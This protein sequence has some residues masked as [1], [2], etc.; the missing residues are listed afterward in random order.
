MCGRY[1]LTVSKK[2]LAEA[3]DLHEVQLRELPP[4]YNI[5]PLQSVPVLLEAPEPRVELFRWGLIPSWAKDPAIGDRMIPPPAF[6][7]KA[8][9]FHSESRITGP[10]G[11]RQVVGMINAR[12]ETLTEKPSFRDP[13]RNQRCLVLADGF[14]EWKAEER[15]KAPY[16]IR[17][18][19][20][21]PFG[22]AGLWSSWRNPNGS[23][24]RSCA[25]ITGEPN[26]LMRS[27]HN[28]M[29]VILSREKREFWLDPSNH[30]TN[31]LMALLE[32]YPAAEMETYSVSKSVNSP[33]ND[34][35]ECVEPLVYS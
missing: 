8:G 31:G 2:K 34:S 28:R 27:I 16:Y 11:R 14:Y 6:P 35:P 18:K 22:F 5:A 12:K 4:Q 9:Y 1:T 30:D 7:P 21:E 29:P 23:E 20:K 24:I 26:E 3:F 25:I 19:S 17:L 33:G 13:F 15:G 32:P 10:S